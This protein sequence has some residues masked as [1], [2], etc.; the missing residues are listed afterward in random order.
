MKV[1]TACIN[2][3]IKPVVVPSDDSAYTFVLRHKAE[4]TC[5]TTYKL[6]THQ[7]TKNQC[8]DDWNEFNTKVNFN[9]KGNE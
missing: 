6:E 3:K 5:Y 2:C 7:N 4:A 1:I 8:V 9:K